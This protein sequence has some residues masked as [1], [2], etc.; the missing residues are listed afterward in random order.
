MHI[1]SLEFFQR[2]AEIRSISK[3]AN[4][5]HISQSALSQQM[6]KLEDAL[7]HKLFIRSNRGVK[8]TP[9]GEIV[10]KYTDNMLRTYKKMLDGLYNQESNEI[11][12]EAE[13]T[14]ATYCLPC[15]LLK[16]KDKYPTHEYNLISATSDKIK[17]D[18]LNDICEIGFVTCCYGKETLTCQRL[19]DEK[20]VLISLPN[21]D[22]PEKLELKEI[23]NHPLIILK[24]N[25]IIKENLKRGLAKNDYSLEDL[26]VLAKLETTEAIKTL[27]LKGYGLA[28]VPYNSIKKEL[29]TRELKISRVKDFNLD[30]SIYLINKANNKLSEQVREFIKGFKKLGDNICC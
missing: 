10:L 6:Q 17:D 15:A 12:I 27:V 5:S 1:E 21:Y 8:L 23:V 29:S 2:I 25:C 11:K 9:A 26:D 19:I 28:L 16:M 14:I 3:V 4:N 13:F 7:G 24:G 30:Y 20:V 18:V 22:I